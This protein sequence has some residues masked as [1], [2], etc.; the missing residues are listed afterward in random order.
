MKDY[1]WN[2]W[3]LGWGWFILITMLF[4]IFSGLNWHYTY[5]A[6]RKLDVIFL[7]KSALDIL[8]ERY[9]RNEIDEAEYFKMRAIIST[10][11]KL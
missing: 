8:K 7:S 1:Y 2:H 6:H 3:Y 5:K 9:A 10:P 4:S 11:E